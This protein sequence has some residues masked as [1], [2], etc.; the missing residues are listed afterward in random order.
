MEDRAACVRVA[1]HPQ[2]P[3]LQNTLCCTHYLQS[4]TKPERVID[5]VSKLCHVLVLAV[6]QRLMC[7]THNSLELQEESRAFKPS[8]CHNRSR[9]ESMP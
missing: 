9:N 6:L 2:T 1:V 8:I 4:L 5:D 3:A 7:A